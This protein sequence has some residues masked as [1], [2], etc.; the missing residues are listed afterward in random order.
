MD[1]LRISEAREHCPIL[2]PSFPLEQTELSGFVL[3]VLIKSQC[4]SSWRM[5]TAA[6][7]Y[8]TLSGIRPLA[9]AG[10]NRGTDPCTL[11]SANQH[12]FFLAPSETRGNDTH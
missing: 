12:A 8:D 11:P 7:G 10:G 2:G 9:P 1:G 5:A 3:R 4:R 6:K